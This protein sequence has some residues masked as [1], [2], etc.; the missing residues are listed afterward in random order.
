[1]ARLF[2]PSSTVAP[3]PTGTPL[4]LAGATQLT[5]ATKLCLVAGAIAQGHK[6]VYVRRNDALYEW[7]EGG[8]CHKVP[9]RT[10]QNYARDSWIGALGA[11]TPGQISDTVEV[12]K[13]ST[14]AEL[15]NLSTRYIMMGMDTYWD[16]QKGMLV[17][18]PEGPVFYKFFDTPTPTKHT[19]TLPPF[20]KEQLKVTWDTYERTIDQLEH[21]GFPMQYDFVKVW[22]NNDHD[23]YKDM[24]RSFAYNLLPKKPL[25]AYVL[26]GQKRNGKST[27]VG[28]HHMIMGAANTSKVQMAQL[29]DPHF[30]TPLFTTLLN[31]P[32]EEEEA[33]LYSQSVF[34]TMCDHG[35]LDVPV[36]RSNEPEE[37]VCDFMSFFPMNHLPEFKGSGAS[38]C[39]ERCLVLPFNNDL[40]SSDKDNTNFAQ[41]TFTADVMAEFMGTIFGIAHY[42]TTHE[43]EFSPAMERERRPLEED[44]DSALMY[45]KKFEEYFDGFSSFKDTYDDYSL[46]CQTNDVKIKTLKEFKFVFR[47]YRANRLTMRVGNQIV[48]CYRVPKTGKL[49]YYDSLHLPEIGEIGAMRIEKNC[50]VVERLDAYYSNK[51]KENY[52]FNF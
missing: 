42:Y 13:M 14:T 24:L 38:A 22:A 36:M 32:D 27:F 37:L 44:L 20:T 35:R 12:L 2:P 18:Q 45:R 33:A 17:R 3:T 7:E 43:I 5:P 1:M 25:G 49:V 46:W 40:S 51:L 10:L 26:I 4:P 30:T 31:A 52:G 6:F 15:E 39:L 34:K 29:G 19:P 48:G 47:E 41:E 21:H 16:M 11:F 23:V 50:S 28:L 8:L 9:A